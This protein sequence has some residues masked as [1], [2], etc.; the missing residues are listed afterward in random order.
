MESIS[1]LVPLKIY[2]ATCQI[3]GV[4]ATLLSDVLFQPLKGF[5]ASLASATDLAELFGGFG[6]SCAHHE[7]RSFIARLL[8]STI[9]PIVLC[10]CIAAIFGC[11][12]LLSHPNRTRALRSAHATY[13]LLLLYVVLPSTSTLIFKAFVRDSRPL[14]TDGE[15]YLVAD[16][17]GE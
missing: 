2:F 6:V 16:Y 15:Q 14:G 13:A 9:A 1:F 7:M 11:R 17:A 5:L 4:F 12:V 8:L 3:L 10:L